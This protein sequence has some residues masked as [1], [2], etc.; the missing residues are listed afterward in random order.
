MIKER[1]KYKLLVT[2]ERYDVG[3]MNI[4]SKIIQLRVG[5]KEPRT[6]NRLHYPTKDS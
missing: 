2:E 4:F 5:S 1:T 6:S 3:I